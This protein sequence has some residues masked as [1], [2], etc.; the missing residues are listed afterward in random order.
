MKTDVQDKRTP[1][2]LSSVVLLVLLAGI[3]FVISAA[4][5][6]SALGYFRYNPYT[7]EGLR[8]LCRHSMDGMHTPAFLGVLMFLL[9][10]GGLVRSGLARTLGTCLTAKGRAN[11]T[12]RQ[13]VALWFAVGLWLLYVIATLLSAFMPHSILLGATGTL[14]PSPFLS[15]FL[16]AAFVGFLLPAMVYAHLSGHLHSLHEMLSILYWGFVRYPDWL[17]SAFLACQLHVILT[18]IMSGSSLPL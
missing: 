12:Y 17:L 6:G 10:A 4:W 14:W 9:V 18:H 16:P 15:G 5:L 3:P 1:S 11:V 8:W 7:G 13:R 2:R